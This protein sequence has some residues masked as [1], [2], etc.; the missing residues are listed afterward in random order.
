MEITIDK[1]DLLHSYNDKPSYIDDSKKLYFRHGKKSRI[2]GPAVITNEKEE[3]WLNN[4]R[5][6]KKEWEIQTKEIKN[7]LEKLK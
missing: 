4:K 5:L 1:N 7:R 2:F 6:S 3:Y